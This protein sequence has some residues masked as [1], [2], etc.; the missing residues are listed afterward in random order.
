MMVSLLVCWCVLVRVRWVLLL[1]AGHGLFMPC[2][3]LT[4]FP[5]RDDG[6]GGP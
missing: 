3:L 4:R 6:V 2:W 1:P 5:L